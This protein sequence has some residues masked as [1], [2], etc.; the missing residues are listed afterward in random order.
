M[1][2][3]MHAESLAGQW[4][5][6]LTLP[7]ATADGQLTGQVHPF[8]LSSQVAERTR[9]RLTARGEPLTLSLPPQTTAPRPAPEEP[10]VPKLPTPSARPT[11][12][13]ADASWR[14]R[15]AIPA[16]LVAG[17]LLAACGGKADGLDLATPA[18]EVSRSAAPVAQSPTPVPTPVSPTP[19][20]T[21]PLASTA[22]ADTEKQKVL[23]DYAAYYRALRPLAEKPA[24]ERPAALAA[25]A[26]DPLYSTILTE[27]AN[28]DRAGKIAYGETILHPEVA[29]LGAADAAI[30]DCQDSS[31]TGLMNK[32]T[33]E[34]L[35]V[36]V[37]AF[38]RLSQMKRGTDGTWRVTTVDAYPKAT[39]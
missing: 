17:L 2:R 8:G 31:H 18:P 36:G 21:T 6:R 19:T 35:T 37:P 33:G 16:A 25:V 32:A 39:C 1:V 3:G 4:R 22:P 11:T 24:Q 10:A 38:L 9:A 12:S 26:V 7:R 29:L 27:Y 30:R 28:R 34:K 20:P 13:R 5:R 23:A 14:S 15:V